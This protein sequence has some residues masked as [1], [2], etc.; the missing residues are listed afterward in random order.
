MKQVHLPDKV[1]ETAGNT[2][3]RAEL[4]RIVADVLGIDPDM[5]Q[6]TTELKTIETFDS[7]NVL[8]LMFDLDE[9]AGIKLTPKDASRLHFYE[10]IEHLAERQGLLLLD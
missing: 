3:H 5:L 2:L 7:V 9:F 4:R 1:T 6:H 8:N 10:D